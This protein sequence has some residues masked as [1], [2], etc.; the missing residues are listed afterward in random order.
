MKRLTEVPESSVAP[1]RNDRLPWYA[2][3]V[4][5]KREQIVHRALEQKGYESFCPV[6]LLSRRWSD[7]MKQI[8]RP[9]FPGYIFCRFDPNYRLPVLTTH[10]VVQIV[11][12][13]KRPV[14]I[15]EEEIASLKTILKSALSC[16]PWPSL[17]PGN[18]VVMESGPLRGVQ[19]VL[20]E[21][22]HSDRLVVSVELLNRAVAVNIQTEWAGHPMRSEA[23]LSPAS[24]LTA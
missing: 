18:Q 7:R 22:R 20:L 6:Y 10:G 2:L 17:A 24:I 4:Q 23:S 13:G 5:P 16:M 3:Q 11:G 19:G 9:L 21:C 8:K 14:P 12:H 15:A 1:A